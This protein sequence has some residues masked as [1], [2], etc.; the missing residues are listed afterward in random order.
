MSGFDQRGPPPAGGFSNGPPPQGG[1]SDAPPR[2]PLFPPSLPPF[3]FDLLL[4]SF[5]MTH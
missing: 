5:I 1:F 3:E 4:I 2:Y